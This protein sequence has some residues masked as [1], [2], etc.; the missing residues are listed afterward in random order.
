MFASSNGLNRVKDKFF[1]GMLRSSL[2]QAAKKSGLIGPV[3]L[4]SFDCD[5][6]KDARV[7]GDVHQ[8]LTNIGIMPIYAVPGEVLLEGADAYG[9]IAQSGAEFINH[10]HYKHS[11]LLDDGET[12][13][14]WNFYDQISRSEMEDDVLR[15]HD[16]LT[17]FLGKEPTGFRSP[18]F[19]SFQTDQELADLYRVLNK[20][21]YRFSTST[22]PVKALE[23][24][25]IY[26]TGSLTEIPV[27]GGYEFPLTI[28]DSYSF[29]Y[30]ETFKYGPSD[31]IR[32]I[33]RFAEWFASEKKPYL[34]NLYADPSQVYDWDEFFEAMKLLAPFNL[35]SYEALLEQVGQK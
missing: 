22:V 5:T 20:K 13:E 10:G 8:K 29:R 15:G 25:A 4:L 1:P 28:L 12:Y 3:F 14:S 6:Y 7:V 11:R 19:G 18:H 33:K 30:S 34:L 17:A 24:A 35:G 21:N 9:V 26:Q 31:Y 32:Q 23:N 16:T 2:S 27:G